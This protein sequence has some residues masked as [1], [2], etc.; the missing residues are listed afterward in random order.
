MLLEL[1]LFEELDTEDELELDDLDK[2]D[3]DELLLDELDTELL[4]LEN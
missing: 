4:E 1:E 2:D 3:E